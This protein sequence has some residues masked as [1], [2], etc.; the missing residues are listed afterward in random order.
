[1]VVLTIT[2]SNDYTVR[3]REPLGKSDYIRLLTCSLFNSWYRD[4]P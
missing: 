4:L 3:F 2:D 1:M